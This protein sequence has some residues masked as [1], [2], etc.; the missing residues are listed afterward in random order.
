MNKFQQ[1]GF[2]II[3]LVVSL[4]IIGVVT[5]IG[6][7]IYKS[8]YVTNELVDTVNEMRMSMKLARSV[9][10]TRGKNTIMCSSIDGSTCSLADGNWAKGWIVGIDLDGNG[11]INELANELLWVKQM[12][13]GTQIIITPSDPAF[14]QSI[15]YSFEGFIDVAAGFNL[16]SGYGATDGY[17][18]RELRASIAGDPKFSKNLSTRC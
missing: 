11:Q 9:A 1:S 14:N 7:P 16:C 4:A 15:N 10:I 3:E 5:A 13:S 17:P 8:I 2:T 18:Q 6:A 12:D